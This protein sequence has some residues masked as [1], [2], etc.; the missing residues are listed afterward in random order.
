MPLGLYISVPFC[1]TKCTYCNFASDVFSRAVFT[2]Y[3]DRVCADIHTTPETAREMGGR[4]ATGVDTLYLGGGTPT[5]L[6]SQQLERLFVTVTQVFRLRPEA[7]ITVECAPGTL[8]P[9]VLDTLLHCG[10][11]RVSLGV[12]SFVDQEAASAGRLHKRVTVLDDVA[13]LRQTGISN[14][15]VD[16]IAGLPH[17]TTESWQES[18]E[19]AIALGVPHVSVYMLEVDEDSRLGRE[20]IAG[21]TKYHAHFVPDDELTAD[22]YETACAQ[23]NAAGIAQYE[24]SNFARE[25]C[26]S[27]H[28]LKYWT[29]QPYLGFG[30]DAHSMLPSAGDELDAVRF[31]TSDSLEQYVAG[32]ALHR[33]EVSRKGALEESFF[34][35]LRLNRGV[36]LERVRERFGDHAIDGLTPLISELVSAGLI[37]RQ[38]DIVRLSVRGRLLSNEVFE[39]FLACG[40]GTS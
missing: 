19:S 36:D 2:R 26:E 30:V 28:N 6:D 7:E 27:R 23:L 3:V 34:L 16:L 25:G 38:S 8:T 31:S 18:V 22:L 20:L 11:N 9:E 4:L 40:A 35:G 32:T 29:R 10:V 15:N 5:V 12:Q 37:E 24:I 21:G 13:R 17:Q 39:R 1:P 14:I 33:T